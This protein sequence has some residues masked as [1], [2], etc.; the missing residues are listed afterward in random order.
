[1]TEVRASAKY[2]KKRKLPDNEHIKP[3]SKQRKAKQSD[4]VSHDVQSVLSNPAVLAQVMKECA[5]VLAQAMKEAVASTSSGVN[6]STPP[7]AS[8]MQALERSRA[9]KA[10]KSTRAATAPAT[11]QVFDQEV[12]TRKR[13]RARAA[14]VVKDAENA[15]AT[16][17]KPPGEC[18]L[19]NHLLTQSQGPDGVEKHP[20][21]Q[22][23]MAGTS[24]PDMVGM[25]SE[26]KFTHAFKI[27]Q[28]QDSLTARVNPEIKR[29]IAVGGYINLQRLLPKFRVDPN[30]DHD[31][32]RMVSKDGYSYFVDDKESSNKEDGLPINSIARWDQAFHVYSAI[33]LAANPSR[34]SEL[35]EYTQNIHKYALTYPWQRVY[36]YDIL[37]RQLVE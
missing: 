5:P 2:V 32:Y 13:A 36:N 6:T 4:D 15:K 24:Q 11:D 12:D 8:P 34:V 17:L 20:Q 16:L 37:F 29:R 28:E 25:R 30:D 23:G 7:P 31:K 33:Y 19:H 22:A 21:E 14:T 35:A 26:D 10:G 3:H 9:E 18:D 27:D 1:M